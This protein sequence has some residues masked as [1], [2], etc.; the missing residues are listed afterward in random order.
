MFRCVVAPNGTVDADPDPNV[1]AEVAIWRTVLAARTGLYAGFATA[2]EERPIGPLTALTLIAFVAVF[3]SAAWRLAKQRDRRAPVWFAYGAILGPIALA[4]LYAAPPGRCRSCLTPTRGWL[5]VCAWCHE[6]VRIVP[7]HT[8]ELLAQMSRTQPRAP[9][10]DRGGAPADRRRRPGS[11]VASPR[12]APA[13]PAAAAAPSR[14]PATGPSGFIL[15]RVDAP[16]PAIAEAPPVARERSSRPMATAGPRTER[17]LPLDAR[18]ASPPTTAAMRAPD[19]SRAWTAPA[20]TDPGTLPTATYITG[21]STLEPGRRYAFK[22]QES[23]LQLLGPVEIDPMAVALQFDIREM[24][25]TAAAGR[26]LLSRPLARSGP[27]LAFMSV[28]GVTPE[29]LAQ[30]IVDAA[31]TRRT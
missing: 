21:S 13:V 20:S 25:A 28:A 18:P 5:T 6:D 15:P 8:Q 11:T 31:A 10:P 17:S 2:L 3:G 1:R 26:L 4:V 24:D 22:V 7:R 19:R 9:R 12:P 29:A 14:A 16:A 30:L 27:V 23:Q